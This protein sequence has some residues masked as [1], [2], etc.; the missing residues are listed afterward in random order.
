MT[1]DWLENDRKMSAY[2]TERCVEIVRAMGATHID[3][4]PLKGPWNTVPY[5]SSHV[6]GGFIMGDKPVNS[7][8]NK[9]LQSWDVSNVFV[10]GANAFPQNPG[11]NPTGTVCALAFW[12]GE[13]IREVYLKSPGPMVQA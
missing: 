10:V 12:A 2:V 11:Y 4:H 1:F 9:Y 13:K 8:M 3:P 5:Q 7:S 6:V